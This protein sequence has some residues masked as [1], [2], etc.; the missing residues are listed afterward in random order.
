MTN[1]HLAAQVDDRLQ[2]CTSIMCCTLSF[3]SKDPEV[4]CTSVSI[5]D[6]GILFDINQCS[7]YYTMCGYNYMFETVICVYCIYMYSSYMF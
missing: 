5:L 7:K 2:T 3:I 1:S 6:P 4:E